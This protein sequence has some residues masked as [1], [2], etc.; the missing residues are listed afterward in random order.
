MAR[1][2]RPPRASTKLPSRRLIIRPGGIGDCILSLPAIEYLQ[3]DYTEIWAPSAIVPLM[4]FAEARAIASSGIDLLGLPGVAPPAGLMARLRSFDSIV[5]WY[6]ANRSE[7]REQ[8]GSL[9][10]PFQFLDAL[11]DPG[12]KIHAA[13][14]FLRQAGGDGWAVPR[15]E[16]KGVARADFAVIHPFSGSARK[17]WPLQRFRQVAAQLGIPVRWCAGPEEALDNAVRFENLYELGCW[18]ASARVYIGNDSGITHLAAAVGTPV[19]AIFGPTDAA[20]WAP[21]GERVT[22][23]SDGML[24]V[25][26]VNDVLDAAQQW[27]PRRN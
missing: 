18:L 8:V 9:G 13:D 7:F 17:N 23:L 14:F 24:D 20:L 10:L 11:P 26:A 12:A 6:G 5:S 2:G 21:R 15:I 3:T 19:V 4:R 1:C 16:C 25:I 27:L 22:V